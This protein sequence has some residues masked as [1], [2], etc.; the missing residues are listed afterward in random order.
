M[1]RPHYVRDIEA[2]NELARQVEKRGDTWKVI[3]I[4]DAQFQAWNDGSRIWTGKI[5]EKVTK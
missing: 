1:A 5:Q 2:L 3:W 4:S